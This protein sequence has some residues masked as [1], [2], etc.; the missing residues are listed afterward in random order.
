MNGEQNL[1]L[2]KAVENTFYCLTATWFL[3]KRLATKLTGILY[4]LNGIIQY[5]KYFCANYKI[6]LQIKRYFGQKYIQRKHIS[7][8]YC[9]D[10]N[11]ILTLI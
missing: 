1:R 10:I 4:L 7:I 8:F 11:Q 3:G 9:S 6:C 2:V 5:N